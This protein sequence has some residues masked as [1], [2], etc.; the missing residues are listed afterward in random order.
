M[1]GPPGTSRRLLIG[2]PPKKRNIRL[3]RT[4][5]ITIEDDWTLRKPYCLGYC[6]WV[7]LS[8]SRKNIS[9]QTAG[10]LAGLGQTCIWY[11]YIIIYHYG[12]YPRESDLTG[13][14][15]LVLSLIP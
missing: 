11:H 14:L 5:L 12:W 6:L 4:P 10:Q 1:P 15:R 8:V 7:T 2:Y 9:G 3:Q 13:D